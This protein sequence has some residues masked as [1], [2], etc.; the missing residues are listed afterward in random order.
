MDGAAGGFCTVAAAECS[1]AFDCLVKDARRGCSPALG[2]QVM[3]A[4][5]RKK[6]RPAGLRSGGRERI[7]EA[8]SHFLRARTLPDRST[9]DGSAEAAEIWE[10]SSPPAPLCDGASACL[11]WRAHARPLSVDHPAD[12]LCAC[13]YVRAH[14]L[15]RPAEHQPGA[16]RKHNIQSCCAELSAPQWLDSDERV[17]SWRQVC[18]SC[19]LNLVLTRPTL[20]NVRLHREL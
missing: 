14:D 8:G 1:T 3:T 20:S 4:T 17:S 16:L 18:S 10:A 12:P 15:L 7:A 19:N 9:R 6:D 13:V 2:A 11:I 5:E